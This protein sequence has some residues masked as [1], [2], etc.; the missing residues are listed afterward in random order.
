MPR[1]DWRSPMG[2]RTS[3][4]G[5]GRMSSSG[6]TRGRNSGAGSRGRRMRAR[7]FAVVVGGLV[8]ATRAVGPDD[9]GVY[10]AVPANWIPIT[11]EQYQALALGTKWTGTDFE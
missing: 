8:V 9:A 4:S 10:P 5:A 11:F 3:S 6:T 7:C 2:D 1:I